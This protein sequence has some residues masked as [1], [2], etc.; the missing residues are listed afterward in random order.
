MK[1]KYYDRI[2]KEE[3]E[4]TVNRKVAHY[5]QCERIKNQRLTPDKINKLPKQK[6]EEYYQREFE[7]SVCSLDQ[8]LEDGFQP[9]SNISLAE[10]YEAR[11]KERKYLNSPEYK[12]FRKSLREELIRA[13]DK[14][15]DYLKQ[16][17]FLR[18][19]KEYS[20]GQIADFLKCARGTAQSYIQRGCIY[21]KDFLER[22]IQTQKRKEQERR[23]R[24]ALIQIAIEE[25]LEKRL[26]QQANE[27]TKKDTKGS[28][29]LK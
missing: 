25:E 2:H 12:R 18:F 11:S 3:I 15:P 28:L 13:F 14:M 29:P 10:E 21:I 16:V 22:D 7:R 8:M 19:F 27:K 4:V 26:A 23:E 6:K 9:V 17:M 24:Q 1:E 20:I 5:L